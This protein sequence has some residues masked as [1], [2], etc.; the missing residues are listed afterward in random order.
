VEDARPCKVVGIGA[1]YQRF[2]ITPFALVTACFTQLQ[3]IF[4]G[5]ERCRVSRFQGGSAVRIPLGTQHHTDSD[6]VRYL[7]S[8]YAT[9]P[10]HELRERAGGEAATGALDDGHS[11]RGFVWPVAWAAER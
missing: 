1:S 10:Q 5:F 2:P 8:F 3:K 6:Q 11:A 4:E 7:A 9:E